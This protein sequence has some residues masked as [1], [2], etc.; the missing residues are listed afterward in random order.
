MIENRI[1]CRIESKGGIASELLCKDKPSPPTVRTDTSDY[2]IA[3]NSA[4]R[5]QEG[6]DLKDWCKQFL[7]SSIWSKC[8]LLPF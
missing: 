3:D 7:L 4:I 6:F 1:E 8:F 5:I 2:N